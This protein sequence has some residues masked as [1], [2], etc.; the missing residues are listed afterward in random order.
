MKAEE[1]MIGDWISYG[2][3]PV[4]VLQLSRTEYK[5]FEP[6][7]LTP[8]ILEKNGFE[9][10][11]FDGWEYKLE[12]DNKVMYRVL[13]RCDYPNVLRISSYSSVYGGF[14]SFHIDNVHQFQH[15]LKLCN[16]D[17]EIKL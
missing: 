15:A 10:L 9:K 13:W 7:S 17:L 4:Q 3:K 11:G 5:G 6:I 2:G 14:N 8:E 1:L 16:I 12:K